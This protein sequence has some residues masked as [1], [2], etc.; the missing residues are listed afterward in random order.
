MEGEYIELL[1]KL[2]VIKRNDFEFVT[3]G[4]VHRDDATLV[5]GEVGYKIANTYT[6]LSGFSSREKSYDSCGTLQLVKLAQY[7]E[8]RGFDFWSL[9]HPHMEY[10]KKLGAKTYS[11][12][13]FLKRWQKSVEKL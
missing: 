4:L 11:R 12:E 8:A 13:A 9:G 1:K 7:L 2:A 3:V 6:S 5:A 10:K